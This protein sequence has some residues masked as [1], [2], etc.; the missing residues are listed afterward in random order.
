MQKFAFIISL[1]GTLLATLIS[2]S[3]FVLGKNIL[4]LG[5]YKGLTF[6][7]LGIFIIATA[8]IGT[9]SIFKWKTLSAILLLISGILLIIN[10]G[11]HYLAII[12]ACLL[13]VGGGL[14]ISHIYFDHK[15]FLYNSMQ[16]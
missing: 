14:I 10:F 2:F 12:A 6:F 11:F 4:F 13:I 9:A 1:V 15:R 3:G 5:S 8:V 16:S 7:Y